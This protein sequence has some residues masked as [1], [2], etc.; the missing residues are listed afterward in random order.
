VTTIDD[1]TVQLE[2][3]AAPGGPSLFA[4]AARPDA[5]PAPPVRVPATR[6]AGYVGRHRAPR[7]STTT[8]TAGAVAGEVPAP[9]GWPV[10]LVAFAA[11]LA[12]AV[13]LLP[14]D[15]LAVLLGGVS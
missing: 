4:G 2:A 1:P 6:Q 11:A 8:I 13:A 12:L 9:L 15:V 14:R 5:S 10:L 3:L 7:P